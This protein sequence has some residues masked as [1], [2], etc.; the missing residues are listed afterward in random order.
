MSRAPDSDPARGRQKVTNRLVHAPGTL[1]CV[2][3]LGARIWR[4]AASAMKGSGGPFSANSWC[5]MEVGR[6]QPETNPIMALQKLYFSLVCRTAVRAMPKAKE[7]CL[8][9]ATLTHGQPRFPNK[10][11]EKDILEL[12]KVCHAQVM[13]K[14]K[15]EQS[16]PGSVGTI[17]AG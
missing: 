13:Q 11:K 6:R 5:C 3:S 16:Q 12:N 17:R 7:G 1:A 14:L 4:E 9:G 8:V 10:L 2:L 15:A